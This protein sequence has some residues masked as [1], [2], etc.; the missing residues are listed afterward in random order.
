MQAFIEFFEQ[1][2]RRI[3]LYAGKPVTFVI[4]CLIIVIWGI[5][6]PV[7]G[8]SNTWQLIINTG[9][10][11]VTF[12]MIF[13]VQSA[14]NRD[15]KALQLKLDELILKINLAS[16]DMIDIESLSEHELDA[17]N[18]KY[19]KLRE[20][21]HTRKNLPKSKHN[22]PVQSSINGHPGRSKRKKPKKQSPQ[23]K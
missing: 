9:T 19:R 22:N 13:L 2:A 14:Q 12:L 11:I 10:T 17:L 21:L 3:A 18:K 20:K 5:T 6:G 8:F 7:F 16:D 4:A 23:E 1:F 15:S